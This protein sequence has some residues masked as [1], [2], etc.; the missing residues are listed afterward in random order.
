MKN[1]QRAKL[2]DNFSNILLK[3]L[4]DVK[5]SLANQYW[6]LYSKQTNLRLFLSYLNFNNS[7]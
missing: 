5:K 4:N 3:Q 2:S 7:L 1:G 6:K